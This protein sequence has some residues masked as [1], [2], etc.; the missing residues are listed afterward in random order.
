V[1]G[2]FGVQEGYAEDEEEL[3]EGEEDEEYEEGG[4]EVRTWCW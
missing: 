4:E 1:P 3:E 2:I